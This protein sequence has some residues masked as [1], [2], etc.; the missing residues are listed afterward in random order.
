M[1]ATDVHPD[2]L[3]A[4]EAAA[5]TLVA[6][7]PADGRVGV[8]S[9][10]RTARTAVGVTGDRAAIDA[11]LRSLRIGGG[12]AIGDALVRSLD[13]LGTQARQAPGARPRAAIVLLSDGSSTEGKV[14]PLAAARR[15]RAAGVPVYTVALGTS[16]GTIRDPGTGATVKVAPDAAALAKVAQ[17]AAGRSYSARDAAS[18]R[19]IYGSIGRQV[20]TRHA[21]Q[22]LSV[23]F[24]AAAACLVLLGAVL[25]L[26]WFRSLA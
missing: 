1:A 12:T 14:G 6:A 11:S 8:V 10:T 26:R 3:A 2:R 16:T 19:G 25:S 24:V 17:A 22:D 18:L 4:A 9:F 21:Q 23:V 20:G 13:L 5:R 15:A 7:L